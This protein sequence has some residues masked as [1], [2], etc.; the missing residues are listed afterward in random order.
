MDASKTQYAAL[1]S[2]RDADWAIQNAR[3][4]AQCEQMKANEISR[5]ESMARNVQW[6][7]EHEPQ[8]ARIVL[9]AHNGHVHNRP[10]AMGSWLRRTYGKDYVVLGFACGEGRYTAIGND[11]LGIYPLQPP[12]ADSVDAFFRAAQIPIGVLDLRTASKDDASSAWLTQARPF[13]MIGALAT[14]FQFGACN[15]QE[16]Y[17]ALIYI[18]QTTP[19]R[20]LR[21]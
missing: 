15:V 2:Q 19:T 10:G 11:G 9:W 3:V 1:T 5:D 8:G 4:V 20:S 17:D 7:L 18:D 6:I 16:C 13:R 12:P 14:D 21:N